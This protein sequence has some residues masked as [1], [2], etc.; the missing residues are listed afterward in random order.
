MHSFEIVGPVDSATSD[1]HIMPVE[2]KEMRITQSRQ[3]LLKY[4]SIVN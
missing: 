2:Q 3:Q 4:T 1:L